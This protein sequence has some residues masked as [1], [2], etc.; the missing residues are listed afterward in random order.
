EAATALYAMYAIAPSME[1]ELQVNMSRYF[2]VAQLSMFAYLADAEDFYE[3]GPGIKEASP[4]TYKMS[5]ALLD[6]FF[7][8][9]DGIAAGNLAHAAKLRFTHA[10]IIIPFAARLGLPDAT[11]SM[12]ADR[13]YSY[14][15]NPWRGE[16]VAP[17]AA[18]ID[19]DFYAN[20]RTLLVR[21]LYN[22]KET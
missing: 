14:F 13:T 15:N 10:E 12:P 4:I 8:E 22:E 6:D 3:K 18:N 20:D 9:G 1:H 21:M 5:Q 19:W 16:S 2:S 7:A 11:A 17:L